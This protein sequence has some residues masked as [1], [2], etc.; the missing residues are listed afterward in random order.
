MAEKKVKAV[1]E[2]APKKGPTKKGLSYAQ[3]LEARAQ[4]GSMTHQKRF[5]LAK[6]KEKEMKG[7]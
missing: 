1:E 7:E 3:T 2:T 6:A 5:A 4:R